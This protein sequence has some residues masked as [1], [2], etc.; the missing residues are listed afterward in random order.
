[1]TKY[2]DIGKHVRFVHVRLAL[3]PA[4]T[5]SSDNGAFRPSVAMLMRRST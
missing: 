1:M 4:V 2:N 5:P 3:Q